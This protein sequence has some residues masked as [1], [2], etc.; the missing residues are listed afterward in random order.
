LDAEGDP[1]MSNQGKKRLLA[2]A[3]RAFRIPENLNYYSDKDF[4]NAER[5]FLRRCVIEGRCSF[6]MPSTHI[7]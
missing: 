7:K 5:L 4:R 1:E 6:S 2:A 3:R